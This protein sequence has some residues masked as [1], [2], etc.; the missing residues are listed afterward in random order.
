MTQTLALL[1]M[2]AWSLIPQS[3]WLTLEI[4]DAWPAAR[5]ELS[6]LVM[7]TNQP[8]WLKG[9]VSIRLVGSWLGSESMVY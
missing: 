2:S 3:L 8:I 7:T 4:L 5:G 9:L 1:P 6:L